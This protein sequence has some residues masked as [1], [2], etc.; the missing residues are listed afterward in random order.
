MPARNGDESD[1][2]G[3]VADL[4]DEVGSFL[5]D[6]VEPILRPLGGVHLV[7]GDDELPHTEGEGEESMFTGLT[8]LGDTSFEL[9]ST[10]GNDEDS[11]IGLRGTG[12][13]VFDKVTMSR[14][15]DDLIA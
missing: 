6:F 8:I 1:S 13:H 10:S 11:A 14:G 5:D 12:D 7:D 4:L 15:V 9:T 2:L 3:V